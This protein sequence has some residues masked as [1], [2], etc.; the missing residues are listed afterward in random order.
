M[1]GCS[2]YPLSDEDKVG[3]RAIAKRDAQNAPLKFRSG[4]EKNMFVMAYSYFVG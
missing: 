2:A 1:V 4:E 3:K